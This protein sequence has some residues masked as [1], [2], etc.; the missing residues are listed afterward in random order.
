MTPWFQ[1]SRCACMDQSKISRWRITFSCVNNKEEGIFRFKSVVNLWLF[2]HL[3]DIKEDMIAHK[4][5]ESWARRC[6]VNS[7]G[8]T[9][10]SP[11]TAP[12]NLK[13]RY[14][15]YRWGGVEM[16]ALIIYCATCNLNLCIDCY[17][18]FHQNANI[19]QSKKSL[20]NQFNK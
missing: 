11:S 10:W 5:C 16:R 13:P 19:T 14:A 8:D 12:K 20:V 6:N 4:W 3:R 9:V 7:T 15:L 17:K 2:K 1:E 18:M